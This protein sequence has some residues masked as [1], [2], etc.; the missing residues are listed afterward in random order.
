MNPP[1]KQEKELRVILKDS[2]FEK[3]EE[4]RN[5]HGLKNM[6]EIVRFLIS[7]EYREIKNND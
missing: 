7:K 2:T 5:Y 6:A 1:S 4:I 3:L